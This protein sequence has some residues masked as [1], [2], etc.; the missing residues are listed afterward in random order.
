MR[1]AADQRL[2]VEGLE[3]VELGAVDEARDHLAHVVGLAQVARHDA[4]EL[5]CVLGGQGGFAAA[6]P[7]R[8]A[9][10]EAADDLARER[11][12]MGV[13]VREVID[14]A[15]GARVHVAAAEGFGVDDLAGRRFHERRAA[16]KDRAL[17]ADDDGLVAHGRHVGAARGAGT[18]DHRDLRNAR[19]R[20]PR[21]VVEDAAEVLAIR[22]HLVLQ[23]QEGAARVDEVDAGQAVL[24]RD[25]LRAQVLLDRDRVVGAALDGRVVRDHEQFAAVDAAD[26]G[27]EARGRRVVAVHA[28]GGERRDLEER[29]AGVEEGL[30]ALARQELAARDVLGARGLAAA[31]RGRAPGAA[32]ARR[33]EPAMCAAFSRNSALPAS[34][35]D[36]MRVMARSPGAA[37]GRSACGGFRWCRRRSRT[38]WRRA[39]CGPPGTR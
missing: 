9:V 35:R 4:V 34:T 38:A 14:D 32:S 20:E 6:E 33:R 12:R 26:A 7:G 3:L 31:G 8:R 11:K 16:E 21:L 5:R 19:G 2:A 36:A 29:A 27:H 23:R 1:E 15:G 30:D 39:G 24:E 17:V 37:R 25:F 18:H 22:E 10:I 13:V 28:A